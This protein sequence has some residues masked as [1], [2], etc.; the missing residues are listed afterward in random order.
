MADVKEMTFE[1]TV[2]SLGKTIGNLSEQAQKAL[3][4]SFRMAASSDAVTAIAARSSMAL[5][6]ITVTT[7][8][9]VGEYGYDV[10]K[11]IVAV[12]SENP[13]EIAKTLYGIGVGAAVAPAAGLLVTAGAS[14]AGA[15][16]LARPIGI[17]GGLA[18][19]SFVGGLAED[20]FME[21]LSKTPAGEWTVGAVGSLFGLRINPSIA[22]ANTVPAANQAPSVALAYDPTTQRLNSIT[23]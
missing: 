4:E 9:V 16:L 18:A 22:Q 3:A 6:Y 11:V 5:P 15:V 13:Y 23:Q 17:V 7:A 12:R 10:F 19:G 21:T 20:H 2:A 1:V 8:K 14:L